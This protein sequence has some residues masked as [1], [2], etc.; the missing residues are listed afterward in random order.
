MCWTS[1]NRDMDRTEIDKLA[2][3]KDEGEAFRT[4]RTADTP[5]PAPEQ[6]YKTTDLA[7]AT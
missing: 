5:K 7:D 3:K 2:N 1:T 4:G 6:T